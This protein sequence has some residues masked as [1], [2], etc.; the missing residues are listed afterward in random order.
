MD[1]LSQLIPEM[2]FQ[3]MKQTIVE[4]G[5]TGISEYALIKSIDVDD[6]PHITRI[7][8]SKPHTTFPF[9]FV[10]FNR[11]YRWKNE[12]ADQ[13]KGRLDISALKITYHP[14]HSHDLQEI[15]THDS[16]ADYY[17]N[18]ANFYE[19]QGERLDEMMSGFWNRFV[20]RDDI[21]HAMK[22]LELNTLKDSAQV[23]K[24]FKKLMIIH[25]PDKGGTSEKAAQLNEAKTTLLRFMGV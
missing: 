9:H 18:I 4:A 15:D 11:L 7:D 6:F 10:L 1:S 23:K 13:K 5:M 25:H 8:L 24:Q 21:H 12:L 22:T 14:Y 17:S 20:R 19:T 2:L 16:L 3:T